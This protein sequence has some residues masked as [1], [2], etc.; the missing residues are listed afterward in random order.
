MKIIS[1][2]FE[3]NGKKVRKFIVLSKRPCKFCG[4]L[5]QPKSQRSVTC[6]ICLAKQYRTTPEQK[7]K[8]RDKHRHGGMREKLL[9][10]DCGFTCYMC[11]KKGTRY[12]I[13]THHIMYDSNNHEKQ[14]NLC[15]SCHAKEHYNERSFGEV[16]RKRYIATL[17]IKDISKK[18]IIEALRERSLIEAAEI[19]GI[20]RGALWKLR[21][22]FSLPKR[23]DGRRKN[24]TIQ[25]RKYRKQKLNSA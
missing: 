13:A 23:K 17:L 24:N 21:K 14:V 6:E 7:R 18:A 19:L 16:G 5:F 20:S 4:E 22:K 15:R 10:Q 3:V 1:A 8:Y 12:E 25:K 11:G 2:T 9:A